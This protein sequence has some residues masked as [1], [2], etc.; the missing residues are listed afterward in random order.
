MSNLH[1]PLV[2]IR[3]SAVAINVRQQARVGGVTSAGFPF[4]QGLVPV[5]PKCG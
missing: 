4:V 5:D 3:W 2:V 1:Q